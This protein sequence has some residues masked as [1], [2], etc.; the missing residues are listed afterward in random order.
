MIHPLHTAPTKPKSNSHHY[1]QLLLRNTTLI[2]RD[3]INFPRE[4]SAGHEI[5]NLERVHC[6]LLAV[7]AVFGVAV[8]GKTAMCSRG[9]F[10]I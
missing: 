2:T 6:T 8:R 9:L 3:I 1:N 7:F 10:F 4:P 5:I